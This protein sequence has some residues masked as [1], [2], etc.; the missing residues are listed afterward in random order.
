[1]RYLT[2][3][4]IHSVLYENSPYLNLALPRSFTRLNLRK[5]SLK[6]KPLVPENSAFKQA[7]KLLS[8]II[9]VSIL[10]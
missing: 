10:V 3:D 7:K 9:L 4:K 6:P 5:K 2:V 8:F 1:M